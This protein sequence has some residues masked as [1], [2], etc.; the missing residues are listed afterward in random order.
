MDAGMSKKKPGVDRSTSAA[1]GGAL[2]ERQFLKRMHSQI[3]AGAAD[4]AASAERTLSSFQPDVWDASHQ[5]ELEFQ[6]A[7]VRKRLMEAG[8]IHIWQSAGTTFFKK[9]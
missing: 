3:A 8:W 2:N 4:A 7:K 5:K 1:P 6:R 9:W